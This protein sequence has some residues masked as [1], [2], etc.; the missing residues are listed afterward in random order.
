MQLY[1]TDVNVQA[2][3][4]S[5]RSALSAIV[6]SGQTDRAFRFKRLC[7]KHQRADNQIGGEDPDQPLRHFQRQEFPLAYGAVTGGDKYLRQP[8]IQRQPRGETSGEI[9]GLEGEG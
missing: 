8:F 2:K 7:D 6:L 4:R 3:K 9:A 1:V 5:R